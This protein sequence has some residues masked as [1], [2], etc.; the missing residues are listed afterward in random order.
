MK[1]IKYNDLEDMIYRKELTYSKNIDKAG[2]KYSGA[3]TA[4][5][6]LPLEK[7]KISDFKL[8]LVLFPL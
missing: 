8:M 7:R 3:S 5:Y 2:I 4:G 6:I 1:S